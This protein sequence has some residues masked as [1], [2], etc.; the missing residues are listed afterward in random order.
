MSAGL[1]P[2]LSADAQVSEL[3]PQEGKTLLDNASRELLNLPGTEFLEKWAAGAFEGDPRP[4]VWTVAAL[5]PFA[6]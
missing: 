3:S 6:Q 4:E 2:D 5:I 1:T